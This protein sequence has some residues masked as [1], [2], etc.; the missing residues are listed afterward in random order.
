VEEEPAAVV[1]EAATGTGSDQGKKRGR[2]RSGT[3]GDGAAKQPLQREQKKKPRNNLPF[4]PWIEPLRGSMPNLM[5]LANHLPVRL[6]RRS[7]E[8]GQN[9]R[10]HAQH[11]LHGGRSPGCFTV[12]QPGKNRP[13]GTRSPQNTAI[14]CSAKTDSSG[15]AWLSAC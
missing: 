5:P 8:S 13:N 15:I 6:V 9:M 7:G 12:D 2:R 3:G 10:G 14:L 11:R 1:A 4:C